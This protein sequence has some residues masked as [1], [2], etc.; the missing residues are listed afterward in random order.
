MQ[1]A[2]RLSMTLAF[3]LSTF[4]IAHAET[5]EATKNS[6]RAKAVDR[7]YCPVWGTDWWEGPYWDK[8]C[9]ITCAE[10]QE[11]VCETATCEEGQTGNAVPSSCECK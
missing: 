3:V 4:A 1:F 11:A 8:G 6:C 10:G 5:T 2:V 9:T 7:F